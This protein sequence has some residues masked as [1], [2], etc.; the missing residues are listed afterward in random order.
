MG[1][2]VNAGPDAIAYPEPCR[3]MAKH[4]TKHNVPLRDVIDHYGASNIIADIT[5]FLGHRLGVPSHDVLVSR[6]NYV[7]IWHKLYLHHQPPYFAPF[8]S[9]RRNTLRES[10]PQRDATG[11]VRKPSVWDVAMYLEKPNWLRSGRNQDEKHGVERYRAGRVRAFFTL[12]AHLKYLYSGPLAYVEVFTPFDVSVP[13]SSGLHSTKPD[14]DSRNQRRTL[15]I[16]VTD[17]S[18]ACHLTPKFHLLDKE[19]KLTAATDI[20][21]HSKHFWLN[22]YFSH[23]FFQLI[24]HWRCHRPRPLD[25]L[26]RLVR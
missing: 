10:A 5:R 4:P 11:R 19:L 21:A 9:A 15:V 14:F 23:H 8:D 18:L 13:L 26:R 6:H 24:E 2:E 3:Q 12:P 22:H 25:R 7:D 16:L 20:F 1:D 17:I